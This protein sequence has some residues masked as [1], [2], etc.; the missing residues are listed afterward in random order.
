MKCAASAALDGVLHFSSAANA[1][2]IL[3][4]QVSR[5]VRFALTPRYLLKPLR[6][7]GKTPRSSL[8]ASSP[9]LIGK[10]NR[11]PRHPGRKHDAEVRAECIERPQVDFIAEDRAACEAAAVAGGEQVLDRFA[12]A[13]IGIERRDLLP[14]HAVRLLLVGF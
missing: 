1:A 7:E 4:F 9:D 3:A 6:G 10:T 12:D 8:R 13:H 5:A 2:Q 14:G 11:R